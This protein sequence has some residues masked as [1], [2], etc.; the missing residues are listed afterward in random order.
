V[1]HLCSKLLHKSG[2]SL[3]GL[4]NAYFDSS[5]QRSSLIHLGRTSANEFEPSFIEGIDEFAQASSLDLYH[6]LFDPRSSASFDV[7]V[8][9]EM[10]LMAGERLL[11]QSNCKEAKV[12]NGDIVEVASWDETGAIRLKDGRQLPA[13]FRQF[14]YG[15]ASTSHAAQGKTVDHG[16]LILGDEGMKAANLRQ[17]YVSNSRFRLSQTI[18][19]TDKNAAFTAMATPEE[20]TAKR[21]LCMSIKSQTL[22]VSHTSEPV[23][24]DCNATTPLEPEVLQALVEAFTENYGNAGSR[25]HSYVRVRRKTQKRR[26]ESPMP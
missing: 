24:L 20:N 4:L 12:K 8:S 11:I 3:Y 13:Y 19:T 10:T 18:F 14:T 23:Y 26:I 16:F 25:T 15:Y 2:N 21:R 6:L 5:D 22:E 17:A 9:R 7:G 1:S